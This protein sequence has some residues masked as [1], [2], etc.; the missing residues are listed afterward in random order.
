MPNHYSRI[1]GPKAC[2]ALERVADF[3]V[4]VVDDYPSF[5]EIGCVEHVD[6][7]LENAPPKDAADL[8]LFLTVLYFMPDGV[9][10]FV[11]RNMEKADTWFEPVATTFRLLDLGLRGLVL[12]LYYSGKHG[13]DYKGK[14]PADVI[15]FSLNRVP[16]Q[17]VSTIEAK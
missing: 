14:T 8:N 12:S 7:I 2:R 10:R 3:I 9:L 1:L 17:V 11:V 15:E 16:R 5:A 13:A 6:A 4:P